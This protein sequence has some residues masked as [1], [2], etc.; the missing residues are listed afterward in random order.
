MHFIYFRSHYVDAPFDFLRHLDILTSFVI[1][2]TFVFVFEERCQTKII[3]LTSIVIVCLSTKDENM[4]VQ[5]FYFF[6]DNDQ[7][8]GKTRYY[9]RMSD[10]VRRLTKSAKA[11]VFRQRI[12]DRK[13]EKIKI[14][15]FCGVR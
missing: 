6:D 3:C 12:V 14:I 4:I 15:F 11:P 1:D 5:S 10:G 2:I 8:D 7:V 9:K 13:I